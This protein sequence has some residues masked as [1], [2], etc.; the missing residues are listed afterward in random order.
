[1]VLQCQGTKL[2]LCMDHLVGVGMGV[3]VGMMEGKVA[4]KAEEGV[5]WRGVGLEE[6]GQVVG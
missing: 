5:G 1:M 2:E 3:G 6:A 4:V